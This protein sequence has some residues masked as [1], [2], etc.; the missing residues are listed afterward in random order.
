MHSHC[1][2]FAGWHTSLC[3][4]CTIGCVCMLCACLYRYPCVCAHVYLVV[5]ICEGQRSTSSFSQSVNRKTDADAWLNFFFFFF[6]PLRSPA[7][8]MLLLTFRVGLTLSRNSLMDVSRG[9]SPI[10]KSF[11]LTLI[12]I[13][14]G[15]I[16]DKVPYQHLLILPPKPCCLIPSH[17]WL[18]SN[19][20]VW[21]LIWDILQWLKL[22]LHCQL[23]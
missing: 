6:P 8:G 11:K 18:D 5:C 2:P 12:W 9:L 4:S 23:F 20:K 19:T 3:L 17:W 13:I 14:I 10:Y 1:H 21:E 16:T 15:T 22:R 7:H